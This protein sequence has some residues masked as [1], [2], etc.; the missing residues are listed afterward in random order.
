[1]ILAQERGMLMK[2]KRIIKLL[3]FVLVIALLIAIYVQFNKLRYDEKVVNA[4]LSYN[5]EQKKCKVAGTTTNY[6]YL[7]RLKNVD[8]AIEGAIWNVLDSD[9][10]V[11]TTFETNETGQGGVV[12]LDYGEYFLE[13][14]SVPEGYEKNNERYK[15]IFTPIDTHYELN[16]VDQNRDNAIIFV[17]TDKQGN[18]LQGAKLSVYN[19]DNE[20]LHKLDTDEDG[21]AGVMNMKPGMYYVRATN[22][23]DY[24]DRYFEQEKN[25]ILRYDLEFEGIVE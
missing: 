6:V 14:Q 1:M 19:S 15:I 24:E 8:E 20:L 21:L 11:V 12:G 25:L 2:K 5:N 3:I 13:E 22:T 16:V 10:N 18:P 9:G 7:T 4:Y 17:V 23:G